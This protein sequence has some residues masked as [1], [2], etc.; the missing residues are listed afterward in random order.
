[1]LTGAEKRLGKYCT[2][3]YGHAMRSVFQEI[4]KDLMGFDDRQLKAALAAGEIEEVCNDNDE[5]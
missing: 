5:A 3:W 4:A 1:M 2:K